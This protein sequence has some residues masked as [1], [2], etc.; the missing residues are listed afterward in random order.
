MNSLSQHTIVYLK[1]NERLS[2]MTGKRQE[3]FAL[4]LHAT[5]DDLFL[6]FFSTYPEVFEK[7]VPGMVEHYINGSPGFPDQPLQTGDFILMKFHTMATLRASIKRDITAMFKKLNINFTAD[8]V[9][10]F[11]FSSGDKGID[12]ILTQFI[13]F[14]KIS[15]SYDAEDVANLLIKAWNTFPQKRHKG[16]SVMQIMHQELLTDLNKDINK[17]EPKKITNK[18]K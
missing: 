6:S 15:D 1:Y 8:D 13:D 12:E 18:N 4:P 5:T 11:V 3:A 10:E 16:K 7:A 9:V 14:S 2:K 17:K